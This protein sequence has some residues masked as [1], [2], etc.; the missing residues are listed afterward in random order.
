MAIGRSA[1]PSGKAVHQRASLGSTLTGRVPSIFGCLS[2]CRESTISA[3]E[4][5]G[6]GPRCR[7]APGSVGLPW[8]S[9]RVLSQ[10]GFA[11]SF[12]AWASL[13]IVTYIAWAI[14]AVFDGAPSVAFIFM[15]L[16]V[17][18]WVGALVAINR[19]VRVDERTN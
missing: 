15:P 2:P 9:G 18:L 12:W 7:L 14:S 11:L 13:C 17:C 5:A 19:W 3:R 16:L 4:V 1:L 6:I 10:K 8:F